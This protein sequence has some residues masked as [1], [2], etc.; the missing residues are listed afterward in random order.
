MLFIEHFM[1]DVG[2]PLMEVLECNALWEGCR[3]ESAGV[4][5]ITSRDSG[6]KSAGEKPRRHGGADASNLAND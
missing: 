4:V 2:N 5:G 6:W 3:R 1:H